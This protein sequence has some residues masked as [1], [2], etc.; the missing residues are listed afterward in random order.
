MRDTISK[1]LKRVFLVHF[2]VA[3]VFGILYFIPEQFLGL[4][5]WNVTEPA[6]Y[7]IVGAAM[8]A[9][10][11]SSLLAY[12]QSEWMKVKILVEM[13][14]IWLI[15]AD[16]ATLWGAVSGSY[17]PFI[18]VNFGLLIAFTVAFIYCYIINTD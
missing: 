18:W 9:L 3:V 7:R 8:I 16:I 2:I 15:G 4:V 10:G 12:R 5:G 17:P 14:I 11:V 13:E 1:I 6:V